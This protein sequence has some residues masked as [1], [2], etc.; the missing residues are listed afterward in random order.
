MPVVDYGRYCEMLDRAPK[1][2]F[3]YPAVP[4]SRD[5]D[6]SRRRPNVAAST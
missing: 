2:K 4:S 6:G 1:G 3:A 5:F